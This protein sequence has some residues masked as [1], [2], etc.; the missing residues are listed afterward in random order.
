[1]QPVAVAVEQGRVVRQVCHAVDA[2]HVIG[3]DPADGGAV[4]DDAQLLQPVSPRV[5]VLLL[6]RHPAVEEEIDVAHG[7]ALV[8]NADLRLFKGHLVAELLQ[9]GLA[10]GVDQGS[11]RP[12]RDVTQDNALALA[13]RL[14]A[15]ARAAGGAH[16][17]DEPHQNS[18]RNLPS[19]QENPHRHSPLPKV[20][21]AWRPPSAW[22]MR[23]RITAMITMSRPPSKP[24]PIC[25]EFSAWMTML[26]RPRAPI[27]A[28]TTDMDS[29]IMMV[30]LMP[31]MME[32]SARGSWILVSSCHGVQPKARPASMMSLR[33][34]RMPRLV[35][36]MAGGIE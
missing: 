35:S 3:H 30:W 8:D 24:L 7:R 2:G 23:S 21:A 10:D 19:R 36:R 5:P 17:Q 6:G 34:W 22:V 9:H 25:S 31:A 4:V 18:R 14:R 29:A 33:T 27:M 12:L 32:G 11:G 20:D 26:P 13:G 15:A 16:Q 1:A 28:A